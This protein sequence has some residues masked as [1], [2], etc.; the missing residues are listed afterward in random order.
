MDE[1]KNNSTGSERT[2]VSSDTNFERLINELKELD[3]SI[4]ARWPSLIGQAKEKFRIQLVKTVPLTGRG[5]L[6]PWDEF[7]TS[8]VIHG[9]ILLAITAFIFKRLPSALEMAGLS[10][11]N[12]SLTT[13]VMLFY[14]IAKINQHSR[15]NGFF[16]VS[17]NKKDLLKKLLHLSS[18]ADAFV[19]CL[20]K[21]HDEIE[22]E[23]M[24]SARCE[25]STL[26]MTEPVLVV[27]PKD[28]EKKYCDL[29]S[30]LKSVKLGNTKNPFT[31]KVF[32]GE[33]INKLKTNPM[34]LVDQEKKQEI[35][36]LLENSLNAFKEQRQNL[37]VAHKTMRISN[38]R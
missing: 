33:F 38:S 36:R 17:M 4:K 11:D 31:G 37:G 32:D 25:I 13:L 12:A 29:S 3:P 7:L 28:G 23:N 2:S 15:A 22:S 20:N 8:Q 6:I 24:D 35:F 26:I 16:T 1:V 5:Q 19:Q 30:L 21:K 9:T 10:E 27:A 18:E 14:S 34:S